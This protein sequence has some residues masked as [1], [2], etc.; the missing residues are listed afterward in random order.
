MAKRGSITVFFTLMLSLILSLLCGSIESVRMASARTQILNGM[1]IGLYSL[2]GEYDKEL[3][4]DYDLF[5]LDGSCGGGGLKLSVIYKELESYMKPV[6]KQNGRRLSL[7]QGGL[8]GYRLVTDEK[9]EVFYQQ[10]V[11]YMKETLGSHG[12]RLLMKRMSESKRLTDRAELEGKYLEQKNALSS[13]D[14]EINRASE[15]SRLALEEAKKRAEEE[16]QLTGQEIV[17]VTPAPP[18]VKNPIRPIKR[19]MHKSILNLVIPK[20]S[21]SKQKIKRSG[22]VS[23]RKL[24]TGMQMSDPLKADHSYLSGILFQQYLMEKLGN[25][26]KPAKPSKKNLQYQIEYILKGKTSDKE[27]LKAVAKEL[28]LIREGVN[29]ASLMA[30]PGKKAAVTALAVSIAA[31]F[32]IPPAAGVIE[33]ALILC[34]T[35]A[36]SILDVREL[37]AGGRVPL[38]K[39]TGDWQISLEN[40]PNL[41]SQMDSLRKHDPDGLSYEDY[42]QIMLLKESKNKKLQRGMDMVECSVRALAGRESFRLDSCIA[43]LEASVDVKANKRKTFTVTR[44]YQYN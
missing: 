7:R 33:A 41:M 8:S 29:I 35:F 40:L 38:V 18:K 13:Y 27:N 43:G 37:F 36:E 19:L 32:L 16:S 4:T 15:E 21:I 2:F 25:F 30:D 14:S 34:W 22:L 42:L 10:V 20:K 6:L 26:E 24:Q 39:K 9:G 5:L 31:G 3:L 28:L 11:R 44:A 1:D 23:A 12:A 17:V